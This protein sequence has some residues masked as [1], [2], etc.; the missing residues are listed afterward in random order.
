ME[1]N[2]KEKKKWEVPRALQS[3]SSFEGGVY[4]HKKG[5]PEQVLWRLHPFKKLATFNF[6]KGS[7][8]VCEP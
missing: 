6:L 4:E 8:F 7:D 3:W 1:K 5:E 2:K